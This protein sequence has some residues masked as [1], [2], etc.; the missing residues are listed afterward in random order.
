MIR[1]LVEEHGGGRQMVRARFW[2][3]WSPAVLAVLAVLVAS[4]AGA[5]ADGSWPAAALLVVVGALLGGRAVQE[6]GAAVALA[7]ETFEGAAGAA[8]A[9]SVARADLVVEPAEAA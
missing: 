4:A 6:S 2:P 5:A 1:A 9:V 8:E 7:A 3:R